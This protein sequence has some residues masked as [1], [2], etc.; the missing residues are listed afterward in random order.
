MKTILITGIA[1]GIGYA[2]A[3]QFLE[4]NNKVIGTVRKVTDKKRLEQEFESENLQIEL[5][6]LKNEREINDLCQKLHKQ[7]IKIDVLINNAGIIGDYT[8][9]LNEAND[10]QSVFAVNVFA[11]Q[12]LI[13]GV[14]D[15]INPKGNVISLS[16]GFAHY[17]GLAKKEA[18]QYALSKSTLN[19]MIQIY[20]ATI[21]D[22]NFNVLY[23]GMVKTR[24]GL[25]E[26]YREADE[27]YKMI[28]NIIEKNT[29]GK[30]FKEFS[31]VEWLEPI[32][33]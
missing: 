13:N 21:T 17:P 24:L 12:T 33:I 11:V 4:N 6:E 9:T 15:L 8:K 18:A 16:T 2:T 14:L 30:C 28:I 5:C 27:I 1:Q 22:I 19:T 23:P 26:A 29:T 25:N 32:L 20:S 10:L 3:K 7:Q 31:E